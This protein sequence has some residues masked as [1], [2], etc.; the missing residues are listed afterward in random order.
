LPRASRYPRLALFLLFLS[1]FFQTARRNSPAFAIPFASFD[2]TRPVYCQIVVPARFLTQTCFY[3]HCPSASKHLETMLCCLQTSARHNSEVCL[4]KFFQIQTFSTNALSCPLGNC[5]I[6]GPKFNCL[7]YL[8]CL[9]EF[10]RQF[11]GKPN[12]RAGTAILN[13]QTPSMSTN[14][15]QRHRKNHVAPKHYD[16]LNEIEPTS[17]LPPLQSLQLRPCARLE[18]MP[19]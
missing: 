1:I 9:A 11:C 8:P 17:I 4:R 15:S 10:P 2:P 19:T 3:T 5:A 13:P 18:E 14:P 7:V 16:R 12:E 6:S